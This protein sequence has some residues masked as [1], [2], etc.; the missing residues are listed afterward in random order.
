MQQSTEID[1][2][3][4]EKI[5]AA[6]H[7]IK[8]VKNGMK[9]GLGTGSTS[10]HMIELLGKRVKE[11]LRI[12]AVPSSDESAY[13]ALQLGIQL[14]TL[15]ELG[16]IDL[17]IDGADEFDP[18]LNLIKGGGG[19]LLREKILAHNSDAVIIMCD[20]SK[21]KPRLG[22]FPLPVEVIPFASGS[23]AST[24]KDMGL[25]ASLRMEGE[26]AYKTDE[27]NYILDMD[28]TGVEDLGAFNHKLIH[29]P[30]VVETGLF[31]GMTDIL[32]MGKGEEV[33]LYGRSTK[34]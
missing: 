20:S 16:R 9:V 30:G 23:I 17:Y 8:F 12:V 26:T 14:T 4:R 6:Q 32:I 27:G 10:F 19:A 34:D 25:D 2:I 13:Q 1:R 11:G 22:G 7:A 31:L 29:L 15:E 21:E 3:E 33:V 28:I 18:Q 24:L 5:Q